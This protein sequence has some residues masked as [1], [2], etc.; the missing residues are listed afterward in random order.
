M[1]VHVKS[2]DFGWSR[3]MTQRIPMTRPSRKSA[4][5]LE[6]IFATLA[7]LGTSACESKQPPKPE[8]ELQAAALPKPPTEGMPKPVE[9]NQA[10]AK[11][12]SS[13]QEA[14]A[15]V[16]KEVPGQK[17]SANGSKGPGQRGAGATGKC[18]EG[19]CGEGQCG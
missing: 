12:A 19:K 6:S 5:S 3:G 1:W 13:V 10:N 4:L 14:A 8:N 16:A 11:P 17:K 7:L 2:I 18:G 9:N 15:A